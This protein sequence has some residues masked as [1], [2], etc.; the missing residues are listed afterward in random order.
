MT[1]IPVPRVILGSATGSL[2]STTAEKFVSAGWD[3][4]GTYRSEKDRERLQSMGVT[5]VHMDLTER[6][7]VFE[8]ARHLGTV[9]AA[10]KIAGTLEGESPQDFY[11]VNARGSQLFVQ[12]LA[13]HGVL[14]SNFVE[15]SSQLVGGADAKN[16]DQAARYRPG[17][18]D[19]QA[20]RS[21]Y[22]ESK[23]DGEYLSALEYGTAKGSLNG[24]VALRPAG[25][26]GPHDAIT[27]GPMVDALRGLGLVGLFPNTSKDPGRETLLAKLGLKSCEHP[28]IGVVSARDVAHVIEHIARENLNENHT[29]VYDLENGDNGVDGA[30][31]AAAAKAAF[32]TRVVLSPRF[33]WFFNA[34]ALVEELRRFLLGARTVVDF[35][36]VAELSHPS[37]ETSNERLFQAF[38]GLRQHGFQTIEEIFIDYAGANPGLLTRLVGQMNG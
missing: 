36:R 26:L 7:T 16:Q 28:L 20:E 21:M 33:P 2:G 18:G 38:P 35:T 8:M 23:A 27:T 29:G 30:K 6:A 10:V 22:A 32:G 31:V 17:G 1:D 25:I 37:L 14:P 5:P 24:W 11:D 9:D 3:V 34:V 12:A 13:D 19:L 15:I 4:V